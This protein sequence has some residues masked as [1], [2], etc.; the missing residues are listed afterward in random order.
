MLV[1]LLDDQVR[2]SLVMNNVCCDILKLAAASQEVIISPIIPLF[3]CP[4][5]HKQHMFNFS[6]TANSLENDAT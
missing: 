1:N 5:C 4:M 2:Q 6:S 3:H